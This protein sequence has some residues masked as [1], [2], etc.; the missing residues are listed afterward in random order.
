MDGYEYGY[1]LDDKEVMELLQSAVS[2]YIVKAHTVRIFRMMEYM[3]QF[4]CGTAS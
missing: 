3:R 4:G 2:I 1:L